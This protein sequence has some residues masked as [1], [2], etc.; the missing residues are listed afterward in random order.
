[1]ERKAQ[2]L[3]PVMRVIKIAFIVSGFLYFYMVITMPSHAQHPPAPA[4]N[5][6]F[7]IVAFT[8]VVIGFNTRGLF[9]RSAGGSSQNLP[10]S[11]QF[12]RWMSAGIMSLANFEACIL[13][14]FA[15]HFLGAPLW[16][17]ELLFG[18][19]LIAM[20]LW[21]PGEPPATEKENFLQG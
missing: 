2:S 19:G 12:K 11:V 1:M 15:L 4:L 16:Q 17:V 9:V 21:S 3:V 14:G 20:V 6:A 7:T 18:V 5:W 13:F 10:A 8:C